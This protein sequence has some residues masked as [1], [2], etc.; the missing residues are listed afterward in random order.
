MSVTVLYRAQCYLA[1]VLHV[2]ITYD[3]VRSVWEY[4]VEH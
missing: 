3:Y 2:Y 1:A 4:F